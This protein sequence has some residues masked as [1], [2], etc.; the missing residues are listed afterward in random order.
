[1]SRLAKK[2]EEERTNKAELRPYILGVGAVGTLLAGILLASGRQQDVASPDL[3]LAPG[4]IQ[5]EGGEP[6]PVAPARAQPAAE[7]QPPQPSVRFYEVLGQGRPAAEQLVVRD[8]PLPPPA[9][10]EPQ[11]ADPASPAPRGADQTP[12]AAAPASMPPAAV[13]EAAARP[14]PKPV[15]VA[16]AKA[17][18]AEPAPYALQVAS[19]S[20][21]RRAD[22]LVSRLS[23]SGHDAYA[24]KVDLV[25]KGDWWRVRVGHF[26]NE[27]AAKWARL[28]L[29][30]LGVNPIVVHDRG[31]PGP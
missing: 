8:L 30:K 18:P 2:A 20:E 16:T 5:V 12:S 24:V 1:M 17:K 9:G 26:P 23:G 31:Q 4:R 14:V 27:H 28:D 19:F 25:G 3:E 15:P 6:A 21:K 22:E 29:V 11:A 13:S 7:E 10:T